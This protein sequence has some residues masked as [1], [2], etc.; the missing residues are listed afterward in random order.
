MDKKY[1]ICHLC[2]KYAELTF[3]HVPPKSANNK[4]RA[5]LKDNSYNHF[6][7][8]S[9]SITTTS[10]ASASLSACFVK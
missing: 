5:T 1:G 2:G 3:E 8:S 10:F 6:I 4:K 7:N 9:R